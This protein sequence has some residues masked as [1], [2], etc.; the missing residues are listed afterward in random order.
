MKSIF[1]VQLLAAI[2]AVAPLAIAQVPTI[3]DVCNPSKSAYNPGPAIPM[4]MIAG[5]SALWQSMALGAYNS[6]Y[7][8][9]DATAPTFHYSSNSKFNLIDTRPCVFG[10]GNSCAALATDTG[11]TWVVW[12]S[13]LSPDGTQCTPQVWAFVSVDS[14]VGNRAFFG[15]AGGGAYGAYLEC[16]AAGCPVDDNGAN[17]SK[18]L[19]GQGQSMPANVAALFANQRGNSAANNLITVA[20]TDIRPEDAY[21]ATLRTNSTFSTA[22]ALIGLGYNV[23][24]AAGTAPPNCVGSTRKAT[25]AQLKGTGI[26][27]N[28]PGDSTFNVLA[29]N[30]LGSDPFTCQLLPGSFTTIPVGATPVVVIHSNNGGQ[31]N[32]LSNVSEFEL[33]QVFSGASNAAGVFSGCSGCANF[34]AFLREPLSGTYNTF[35]ETIMRH[36]SS[37]A[38]YRFPQETG[39]GVQGGAVI[40]NPLSGGGGLGYRW[41]AIGTGDEVKSVLNSTTSAVH[42]DVDGIGY[43][44][45]SYGNVS[46]IGDSANYS[47]VTIDDIDPIFHQYDNNLPG[48]KDP[49]QPATAGMLPKVNDIAGCS[50]AWPCNENQIWAADN[51]SLVGGVEVPS[52]SFPNLRNGSYPTWSV[53]RLAA[54]GAAEPAQN[55]VTASNQYVV[56]TTP[57]YVPFYPVYDNNG[58]LLDPGLQI[59]RSHFGCTTATC[60]QGTLPNQA[61]CG[62]EAGR[63]AGGFVLPL[64]DCE[65]GETQDGPGQGAV[66]TFE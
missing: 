6:G 62:I 20:A 10:G 5:S 66:V 18:T 14:V 12:D 65:T 43:A 34:V 48:K 42:A 35:E 16:P 63:D 31:L 61:A 39:N 47:Y 52:Y 57:D 26:A 25:L 36:P 54:A 45:F 4:T 38:V 22:N 3:P 58:N 60:G 15:S 44:F 29:F 2:V 41:R 23:N 19:W 27:G 64:G 56:T 17:I 13:T 55:L 9:S 24:N 21:F 8:D 1:A 7:G 28:Y 37:L 30:L 33:E 51:Y 53:L 49:G 59:E 40:N 32:G 46:S 11:N 50:G